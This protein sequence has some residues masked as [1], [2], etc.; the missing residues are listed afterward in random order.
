MPV[1]S[2]ATSSPG[3]PAVNSWS[4]LR[5][6][7]VAVGRSCGWSQLQ[8]V[9]DA[10]GRS[11]SSKV[12]VAVDRSCSWSQLQLVTVAVGRILAGDS[13]QLASAISWHMPVGVYYRKSDAG[14]F[15]F[16]PVF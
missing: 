16:G 15:L 9:A 10:V 4:Q 14:S 11:C 13:G 7:A 12:A 6:A 3:R 1:L 2:Y 8:L 5:L